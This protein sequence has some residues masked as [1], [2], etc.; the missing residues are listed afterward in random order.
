M[1]YFW[2]TDL[3]FVPS[4]N[5]ELHISSG[6]DLGPWGYCPLLGVINICLIFK[7]WRLF[8]YTFLYIISSLSFFIYRYSYY[9]C[10]P[11]YSIYIFTESL[12]I[13][14]DMT[15]LKPQSPHVWAIRLFI[16][17]ILRM[18]VVRFLFHI[19]HRL[20]TVLFIYLI[21]KLVLARL[22]VWCLFNPADHNFSCIRSLIPFVL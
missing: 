15:L 16:L 8:K 13:I 20:L 7:K 17:P 18:A 4:L 14:W 10:I 11:T 5:N 1:E 6:Q 12:K 3:P 19:W 21:T 9:L 22:L 2:D